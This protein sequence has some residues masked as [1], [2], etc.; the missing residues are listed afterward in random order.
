MDL[1]YKVQS[2]WSVTNWKNEL[3]WNV[4]EEVGVDKH[5]KLC[6][7]QNVASIASDDSLLVSRPVPNQIDQ[8]ISSRLENQLADEVCFK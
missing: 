2:G 4:A 3:F 5:R 8:L 6:I 7:K 1:E